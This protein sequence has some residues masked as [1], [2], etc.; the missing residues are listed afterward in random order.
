MDEANIVNVPKVFFRRMR[1]VWLGLAILVAGAVGKSPPEPKA[2]IVMFL[3]TDCPM[4]LRYA[5]RISALVSSFGKRGVSFEA[6]FPNRE[7]S[8]GAVS[9]YM[10]ER[11]YKFPY[12]L[13]LGAVEAKR[14]GVEGVP[15]FVVFDAKGR[16]VYLGALDDNREA[17]LAKK[18]Y[19]ANALNAILAGKSPTFQKTAL[20]G[21]VL[22]PDRAPVNQNRV[23]YA[24]HIAP[25]LN[26]H[27]L[28]CHRKGQ[29]APFTLEG[30]ENARRWSP[31]LAVVTRDR[32]MPLWKATTSL[33]P[34]H[35][36][37][38]L[39]ETEIATIMNW[40]RAMAPAGDLSKA[41]LPPTFSDGWHLGPPD[42]I[43]APEA[44]YKL[45]ADGSDIYR[46][47]VLKTNFTETKWVSAMSALPG[48]VKI[49]HRVLAYVD[50]EGKT[51][52]SGE[53]GQEGYTTYGDPGFVPTQTL[54]AWAPAAKD[55][56]LPPGVGFELK[57]GAT[58]VMQIHYH[59]TGR[60]E[61][62]RTQLGLYF[63]KT[64]PKKAARLAWWSPTVLDIPA[65]ERHVVRHSIVLAKDTVLY[66]VMP[67]MRYLGKAFR[68]TAV[69]PDGR[70]EPLVRIQPWDFNWQFQYTFR[71]PLSLPKGTRIEMVGEYNNSASNMNN[72]ND[73]PKLV[74][75]G[76]G[77][78][79]EMFALVAVISE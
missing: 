24:E 78:T 40:D 37:N 61:A 45:A 5:P 34:Y 55:K 14:L 32:R 57:P 64:P 17:R 44:S 75:G 6:Q 68:A 65:S 41:P 27:C 1:Y 7:V 25:I 10:A 26:K 20:Q 36:E 39:T 79:D 11:G 51:P 21:C 47:F 3:S 62:D 69:L 56:P 63:A 31:M 72:P 33:T 35:G 12:E 53:D 58:V 16:K 60:E 52:K 23:T 13:D 43:L 4:A 70:L 46:N 54:G 77:P 67:H 8:R 66:S 2:R 50:N 71:E 9:D 48:N 59:R 19:V 38:V 76:P 30:Y 15:T 49:V 22:M 73:P 42:L 74:R 28:E 29:V 18:H